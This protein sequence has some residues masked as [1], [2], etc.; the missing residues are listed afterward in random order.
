MTKAQSPW[1]RSWWKLALA[2]AWS[3]PLWPVALLAAGL[4]ALP[5][6]RA[7]L[8]VRAGVLEVWAHETAFGSW[9]R[10]RGW[11]GFALCPCVF[12]WERAQ[13]SPVFAFLSEEMREMLAEHERDH[14]RQGFALGVLQPVTYLMLWLVYGYHDHPFEVSAR[15]RAGQ[16]V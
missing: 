6:R 14:V 12:Y 9:M 8:R 4:L 13:M 11:A 7:S 10:R 16:R 2:I 3:L 5:P 15:R 1:P